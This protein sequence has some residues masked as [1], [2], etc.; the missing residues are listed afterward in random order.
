LLFVIITI[1]VV[2]VVVVVGSS[3]NFI[4]KLNWGY[5]NMAARGG[6]DV[7][8]TALPA[9]RSRVLFPMESLE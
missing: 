6:S 4:W 7:R 9:E 8:G 5:K 3:H 2:V 1:V